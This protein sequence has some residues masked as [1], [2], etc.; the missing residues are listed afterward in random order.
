ML[1]LS[2]RTIQ[3]DG[4]FTR[5]AGQHV[6]TQGVVTGVIR[7]GFYIQTPEVVWDN[8]R[9]DAVFVF[10]RKCDVTPG[11]LIEVTGT[12]VDYLKHDTARPNTQLLLSESRL[13]QANGPVIAPIRLSNELLPSATISL[14]ERLNSLEGMLVCIPKGATFIAPSN[15]F[16][17]YVC[18]FEEHLDDEH[19]V[20]SREGGII[21]HHTA[22]DRWFPGFRVRNYH[23]AETV[24][25]GSKLLVDVT[26]P[27]HYRVNSWQLAVDHA[28][29][30]Q[31]NLVKPQ[32]SSLPSDPYAI[33]VMTLNCF[34]LD[35]KIE[36]A[37]KVQNPKTDVDDDWG[38]R[39]FH[40]LAQAVVMQAKVPDIIALQ[41]I[42]DNDGAE[43]SDEVN[44]D[45]SYL[46]LIGLIQKLCGI[47][48]DWV[49][50]PPEPDADGGQPGGNIRN[51]YLY[52]P[53]RVDLIPES[54]QLI[55][56]GL[57]CFEDS[58]KPLCA[59]FVEKHS[60]QP[61]TVINVHLV[62]KRQQQ[63]I[64]A[65]EN[66]GVDIKQVVRVAQAEAICEFTD[67][68]F[69]KGQGY[70]ITG[71]FNDHEHSQTLK[72]LVGQYNENLV[73]TV[74]EDSRYD[75]NH[76]GKLQVLMHG[77]IPKIFLE[78]GQVAYEIIHG[79][80]LI[81][82]QPGSTTDKP[83]DHAYVICRVAFN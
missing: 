73:F 39:R 75:Y 43:I 64:F 20:V 4:L 42:Q 13:L 9:S 59:T 57:A 53:T 7:K 71:D 69:H 38:D 31:N 50:I 62:S 63:S 61:L 60:Q 82:V 54:V 17:D 28:F 55:G 23:N 66:P 49:D 67:Q 78:Q 3:G 19:L 81:G 65:P 44:A 79:N 35:Q 22:L 6:T 45:Q 72:T 1:K 12:C 41:E 77:I 48:Y 14:A 56:Q 21:P 11:Q 33:T 16:G 29:D 52:N 40:T 30:V 47:R 70:Y 26:G 68:L 15:L 80:E 8:Q 46:A 27:L 24:N 5:Y 51:G 83:S 34:N 37:E 76:R 25:V 2:I 74:E 58:R 36:S 18:A 10:C 32:A